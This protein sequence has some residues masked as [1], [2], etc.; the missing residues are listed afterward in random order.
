[1]RNSIVLHLTE[2]DAVKFA[3]QNDRYYVFA[4]VTKSIGSEKI[5]MTVMDTN[6]LSLQNKEITFDDEKDTY[7]ADD[8]VMF[9]FE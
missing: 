1:M 9:C 5:T 7:A 6:I 8:I 2:N 3:S 4:I